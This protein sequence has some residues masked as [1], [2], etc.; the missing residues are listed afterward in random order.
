MPHYPG[1]LRDA[2]R[3]WVDEAMPD[4]ATVQ[5]NYRDELWPTERLLGK[6]WHCSDIMPGR[7]REDLDMPLGSTYARA[8]Q[9]LR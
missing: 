2:F 6:M 3:A 8:A 9:T 4:L 5:V 1:H 7:L